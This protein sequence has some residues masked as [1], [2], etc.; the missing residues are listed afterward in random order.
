MAGLAW[1]NRLN[2]GRPDVTAATMSGGLVITAACL[3]VWGR[4]VLGS[5]ARPAAPAR[6][7][8]AHPVG[9]GPSAPRLSPAERRAGRSGARGRG[10][11]LVRAGGRRGGVAVALDRGARRLPGCPA[12]VA[13][14][15][16]RPAELPLAA[17]LLAVALRAGAPVD[18]AAAAVG[19]ALPGPLGER[20]GRVA[21]VL[22]LGATPAEAWEELATARRRPTG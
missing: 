20:L 15:G 1:A 6:A 22:Q 19:E 3:V 7:A 21:R 11:G 5:S 2:A 16:A 8:D 9:A 17:D 10:R 18:R 12:T 13:A 4:R 14:A